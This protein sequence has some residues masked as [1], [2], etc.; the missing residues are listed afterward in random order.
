MGSSFEKMP[1]SQIL[2]RFPLTDSHK[3]Q[4]KE[5]NLRRDKLTAET[6]LLK[7]IDYGCGQPDAER[8]LKDMRQGV[9]VEFTLGQVASWGIKGDWA[10]AL[11]GLVFFRKPKTILELGTCLGFSSLLMQ[12][13]APWAQIHTLEGAEA[14]AKQALIHFQEAD[15]AAKI[16]LHVGP[17]YQSLP[18]LLKTQPTFDFAFI[19]GH[20]DEQ[21]TWDYFEKIKPYSSSRT[22]FVFD[23]IHWS[24]GM[25]RV[26]SKIQKSHTGDV[27]ESEKLGVLF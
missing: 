6:T 18:A 26:W 24:P 14:L 17:F 25:E 7:F 16:Q 20:H 22:M 1:L 3:Q 8:S 5:I 21:A 19:D 11:A 13:A 2:K 15:A 12:M 9:T 4:I 27:I 10:Q 23:D